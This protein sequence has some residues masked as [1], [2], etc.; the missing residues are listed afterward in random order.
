MMA[1]GFFKGNEQEDFGFQSNFEQI[2]FANGAGQR[3]N[4]Q[5]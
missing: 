2:P 3:E 4:E 5:E 1:N